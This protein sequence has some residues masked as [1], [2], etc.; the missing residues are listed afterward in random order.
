[1]KNKI[2]IREVA[3]DDISLSE[4]VE[5][6][7]AF[8]DEKKARK[9]HTPNTEIVQACVE[10]P[11]LLPLINSADLTVPDGIGVIEAAKILKTP[12]TNGRLPGIELCEAVLALCAEK[13]KKVFLLGGKPGVADR[14]ASKLCEKYPA[15]SVCGT[16]DGYFDAEGEENDSLIAD[17]NDA[18]TDFLVVCLGAPKQE[19]WMA[20]NQSSLNIS[21]MGGFG[22]SIDVFSG[23]SKRAPDFFCDHGLEWFYRLVKEPKRI[24]R[25]AKLPVFLVQTA[26]KKK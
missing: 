6:C 15:L 25:M 18:Q 10:D 3:F 20:E 4:A 11:S 9:I 8:L 12:F 24:G 19:K 7:S 21:L 16:H 1:M 14:A 5:R 2:L 17:I 23:D 13:K 22:G 26:L